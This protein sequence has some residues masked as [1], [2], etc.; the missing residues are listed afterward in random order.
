MLA[1]GVSREHHRP[2]RRR[3]HLRRRRGSEHLRH[4]AEAR[5]AARAPARARI[6]A[7]AG[8]SAALRRHAAH[9]LLDLRRRSAA[10]T[11]REAAAPGR[12]QPPGNAA[13]RCHRRSRW[14]E[15][16]TAERIEAIRR[17]TGPA[18]FESQMLLR[19]RNIIEGR[20]DPDRLRLYDGDL[21]Y[22]E[23][24]REATLSLG[25][26]RLISASCWW[27]PA[28]GAP[29]KGTPASWPRSSPMTR[30]ATGCIG[31]AT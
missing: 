22:T 3:R 14:P 20:L 21:V 25:D 13:A 26:R 19:P 7:R 15:R 8:R 6:R 1:K 24:N 23:G 30:A 4:R 5:R 2:A 10:R 18:K 29:A 16:F 9:L 12:V 31:S 28:Y 27:D 11:G 17:R